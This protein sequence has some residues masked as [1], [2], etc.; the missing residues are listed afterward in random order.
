M[1]TPHANYQPGTYTLGLKLFPKHHFSAYISPVIPKMKLFA[2]E[3]MEL[4]LAPTGLQ[5]RCRGLADAG[6]G[7]NLSTLIPGFSQPPQQLC[8]L[9]RRRSTSSRLSYLNCTAGHISIKVPANGRG[10]LLHR[11]SRAVLRGSSY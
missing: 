4:G 5:R 2:G 1:I 3:R 11:Q 8:D 9:V 6:P 7:H 10:C